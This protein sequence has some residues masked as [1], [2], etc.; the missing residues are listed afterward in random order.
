LETFAPLVCGWKVSFLNRST[1]YKLQSGEDFSIK[2]PLNI[3]DP[4][5]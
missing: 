2:V 4:T 1:G 3:G 5:A